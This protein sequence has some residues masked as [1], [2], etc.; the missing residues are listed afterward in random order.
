MEDW[1]FCHLQFEDRHLARHL[2]TG[3]H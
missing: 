1:L 2:K 3:G